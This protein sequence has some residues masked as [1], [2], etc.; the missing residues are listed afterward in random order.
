MIKNIT[1]A[2]PHLKCGGTERTAVEIANFLTEMGLNVTLL[3]MFRVE[4]FYMV[5]P[6]VSIIE[7]EF[8][9]GGLGGIYIFQDYYSFYEGNLKNKIRRL[10]L[11][12][13]I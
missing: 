9:R 10:Y 13:V 3:L 7:P 6:K 5:H 1:I 12:L 4:K 2:L 11:P 8:K